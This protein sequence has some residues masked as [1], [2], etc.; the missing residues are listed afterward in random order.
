MK[1]GFWFISAL[2]EIHFNGDDSISVKAGTGISDPDYYEAKVLSSSSD[3]T[4]GDFTVKFSML[5]GKY[6]FTETFK[7]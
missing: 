4:T 7:R 3:E 5:S 1:Y 6:V 2:S